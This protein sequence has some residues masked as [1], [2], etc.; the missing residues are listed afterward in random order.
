MSLKLNKKSL[1]TKNNNIEL[2]RLQKLAFS[3]STALTKGVKMHMKSLLNIMILIVV[4][5]T[6]CQLEDETKKTETSHPI[7]QLSTSGEIGQNASKHAEEV[8]KKQNNLMDVQAIND[9]KKLLI[10][11]QLPHN[12]R[13]Q[14]KK[15]EKK[16][17]KQVEKHFPDREI[18]L[19][20]D[21]KIHLEIKDLKEQLA[22]GKL[23]N[24][25][26]KKE[27]DRIIKLSKEKT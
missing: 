25:K 23:D 2:K 21:K 12:D 13:F 9:D 6:G 17:T 24:K 18:T 19:S 26:L 8:L 7:L 27:I 14:M 1:N 22:K 3:S 20:L 16:L 5:A 15:I 11:A 10:A 4:M